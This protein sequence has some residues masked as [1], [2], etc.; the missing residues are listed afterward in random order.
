MQ[1]G[2]LVHAVQKPA[3]MRRAL[4]LAAALVCVSGA[5]TLADPPPRYM[6][7][8]TIVIHGTAPPP[9]VLPHP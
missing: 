6:P 8:E 7:G 9:K 1:C 3:F 2:E 4:L 5:A